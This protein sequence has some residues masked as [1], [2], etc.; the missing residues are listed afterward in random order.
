MKKNLFIAAACIAMAAISASATDAI[1]TW[2]GKIV[3]TLDMGE[4][5]EMMDQDELEDMFQA[6][7]KE[8]CGSEGSYE[9]IEY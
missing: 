9:I 5:S 6:I 4:L 3:Y 2:C 1:K 8:M 7:N